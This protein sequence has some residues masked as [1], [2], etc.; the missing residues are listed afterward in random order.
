LTKHSKNTQLYKTS[1]NL[2]QLHTTSQQ[3]TATA[4]N[5]TTFA[6]HNFTKLVETIHNSTDLDKTLQH[7]KTCT[8]LHKIVQNYTQFYTNIET[9][10]HLQ[11][12]RQPFK[13]LPKTI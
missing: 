1:Q 7:S 2:S 12:S 13:Q 10:I 8:Q 4:Q 6:K 9:T 5:S 3:Y 11:N